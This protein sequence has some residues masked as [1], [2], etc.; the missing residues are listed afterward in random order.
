MHSFLAP[1][2]L[3]G[4]CSQSPW[5]PG[6][7]NYFLFPLLDPSRQH[8]SIV[9]SCPFKKKR[10]SKNYPAHLH[11]LH[12]HL[13]PKVNLPHK[14]F[15]SRS[16]MA[17]RF[18]NSNA[19]F[20]FPC[21]KSYGFLKYNVSETELILFSNAAAHALSQWKVSLLPNQFPKWET[22]A[23]SLSPS[24]WKPTTFQHVPCQPNCFS[25]AQVEAISWVLL[26]RL[27]GSLYKSDHVILLLKTIQDGAFYIGMGTDKK[28]YG[29]QWSSETNPEKYIW[30][31]LKQ[32]LKAVE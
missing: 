29:M 21:E 11:P 25:S 19:W 16:F 20:Y 10:N 30:W 32:H 5:S 9:K 27:S 12:S 2:H 18:I 1:Q 4:S 14:Y 23:S 15:P 24:L 31:H 6:L 8:I 26:G 13:L 28:I 22:V 3:W 17:F 7:I